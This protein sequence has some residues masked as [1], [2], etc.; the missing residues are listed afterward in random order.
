ME[1]QFYILLNL[2]TP[3]GFE[4][5]GQYFFGDDRKAAYN[6]F[7]RLEGSSELSDNHLLHID[8]IETANEL[9]LKIKTIG[10]TLDELAANTKLIAKEI[11]RL[12]NLKFYED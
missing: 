9:P 8:L 4:T 5:Y 1:T 12:K 6:L 3:E 7:D 2:K 10:C 11:F